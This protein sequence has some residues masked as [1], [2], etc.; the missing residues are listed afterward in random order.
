MLRSIGNAV[1][2]FAIWGVAGAIAT[3]CGSDGP[4]P[5]ADAS[6]SIDAPVDS[7]APID[8]APVPAP[9]TIRTFTPGVGRVGP[10]ANATL[11]AFQDGDGPWT[12]LAGNGGVYQAIT[13]TGRYAVAIGCAG[14]LPT[15][16]VHYASVMD[17]TELNAD[18]CFAPPSVKVSVALGGLP[19]GEVG[20]VWFG[21]EIVALVNPP[22]DPVDF[23]VRRGM[24]DVFVRARK[25]GI[26]TKVFRGPR[27]DLQADQLLVLNLEALGVAPQSR[28]LSLSNRDPVETVRVHTSHATP[29]SQVQWP[30]VTRDFGAADPDTYLTLPD[31][32]L[33]PD[34]VSNITVTGTRTTSD[35]RQIQRIVRAAM[36]SPGALTLALP[37]IAYAPIAPTVDKATV[38]RATVTIPIVAD[39]Q[40][41]V[42]YTVS[43][44]TTEPLPPDGNGGP[45]TLTLQVRSGWA[46]AQSSV[47]IV[48]PDLS[49]LPGW[50][51][52]M[53]LV[54]GAEMRWTIQRNDSNL[55]YDPAPVDGRR[56]THLS[57]SGTVA[58]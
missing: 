9:I 32:V 46:G 44:S 10:T 56:I 50:A 24:V 53:A 13:D 47:T 48:T 35:D 23:D 38:P 36:K 29:L 1:G 41:T 51:A 21:S 52:A 26:P 33:K 58:P 54:S 25:A 39:A 37:A 7:S 19:D 20:E 31:S 14:D 3:G 45:H 55:G 30:V 22:P 2:Y 28:S 34:D 16:E 57:A 11:V 27:L 8:A 42:S 4:R 5:A 18:G 43:L 40:K 6:V 49:S 15:V 12:A 17:T